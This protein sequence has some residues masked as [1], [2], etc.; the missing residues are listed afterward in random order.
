MHFEDRLKEIRRIY[1]THKEKELD[2]L[3]E[4]GVAKMDL[5]LSE[6]EDFII[7]AYNVMNFE[8]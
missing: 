2:Y 4:I 3:T 6:V 8:D 1:D 5:F 7:A